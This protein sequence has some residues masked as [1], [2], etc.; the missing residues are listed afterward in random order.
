MPPLRRVV[1]WVAGLSLAALAG[2]QSSRSDGA[3]AGTD[4]AAPTGS[5]GA[6]A[7][8]TG[9]AQAGS[10]GFAAI[11]GR[12]GAGGQTG[13]GGAPAAT[14][15]GAD[16]GADANRDAGGPGDANRDVVGAGD[17]GRGDAGDAAGA[18]GGAPFA[19]CPTGGA[20]CVI[21]PF[22]DSITDGFPAENGGYRVE[23]F[24]RSLLAAKHV[25]FVGSLANGPL[26]VDNVAFPPNH[27]GHS[28]F[29]I[30]PAPNNLT[31]GGI[32]PLANGA[33]AT[34]HPNII[35]LLI[36]T[37]DVNRSIDL[38]NAP[39]RLAALVDRIIADA[40]NALLAVGQLIPITDD[41][42]NPRVQAYNAAIPAIVQQRAAAGKHVILVDAYNPFASVANFKTLLMTDVLHPN[43]AGYG[44]LG[45]TWYNAISSYLR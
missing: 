34:Y 11:G 25:T 17:T 29:S 7:A 24:H 33:I 5:G 27:E 35:L 42:I 37:N 15:G 43:L 8:G 3:D 16:G 1:V 38:A 20:A 41:T 22:G 14:D 10:G 13:S 4:T 30:D 44:L 40:P 26:M 31:P 18:D 36:G 32:S 6:S 28:G 23:L 19:P 21:L 9:G 2:C 39:T 45:D 12:S